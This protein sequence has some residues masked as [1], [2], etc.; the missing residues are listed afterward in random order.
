MVKILEIFWHIIPHLSYIINKESRKLIVNFLRYNYFLPQVSFK[1]FCCQQVMS[2]KCQNWRLLLRLMAHDWKSC[3]IY[4]KFNWHKQWSTTLELQLHHTMR[5]LSVDKLN[6]VISRLYSG[7]TTC[8]TDIILYWFQH[9]YH[10]KNL[11]WAC[12]WPPQVLWWLSCQTLPS[13]YLS[14]SQL[15]YLWEGWN[16]SISLKSTP[17]YHQPTCHYPDSVQTP[18][19]NWYEGSGKEEK[20]PSIIKAK[21]GENELCNQ[22]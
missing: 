22:A 11:F 8:Q 15:Y 14:C 2:E 21:E 16:S 4:K 19:V 1:Q 10:L 20:A 13:Q 17:T 9:W 5:P 3:D 6:I 18:W 7:K 12:L